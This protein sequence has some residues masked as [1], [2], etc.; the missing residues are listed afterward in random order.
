MKN[1]TK[2]LIPL[3][4]I[5]F[6]TPILSTKKSLTLQNTLKSSGGSGIKS[7]GF[8]LECGIPSGPYP[9]GSI[10]L[11]KTDKWE[12]HPD[13]PNKGCDC[14]EN[15]RC[16]NLEF[17]TIG[18]QNKKDFIK[19]IKDAGVLFSNFNIY[20]F[21]QSFVKDNDFRFKSE[22]NSSFVIERGS[23][24]E[25]SNG[26]FPRVLNSFITND[27]PHMTPDAN[28][29]YGCAPQVTV[30]LY[31]DKS[32]EF[33]L[34]TLKKTSHTHQDIF[35]KVLEGKLVVQSENKELDALVFVNNFIKNNKNTNIFENGE[36][37]AKSLSFLILFYFTALFK[38]E[39][40]GNDSL[41][42]KYSVGIM[43]RLTFSDM[44]DNLEEE[45][46]LRTCLFILNICSQH[47]EQQKQELLS[48]KNSCELLSFE[49]LRKCD[50]FKLKDYQNE[51][52][53][54]IHP[55]ESEERLTFTKWILSIVNPDYRLSLIKLREEDPSVFLP[56][57]D[58]LSPPE[59]LRVMG[60]NEK[61]ENN[62][63]RYGMGKYFLEDKNQV[64]VELRRFKK[65]E[66]MENYMNYRNGMNEL[67]KFMYG[68]DEPNIWREGSKDRG[69]D[70]VDVV[71][72]GDMI[73]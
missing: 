28:G 31:K 11:V 6:I 29:T 19:S 61:I 70:N 30:S 66:G 57:T 56:K 10:I 22:T 53:E 33:F 37:S 17:A 43:S 52:S 21:E 72:K 32:Y 42:L 41:E 73:I 7:S 45:I 15:I 18:G 62:E 36:E 39:N 51:E 26:N 44:Y 23:L 50:D 46:K 1:L 24:Y 67:L 49:N 60:K 58:L 48:T 69:Q 55:L 63:Y 8:E 3:V 2:I 13:T 4:I 65:I 27:T 25:H 40:F 54:F 9:E 20:G 47:T 64:L 59:G 12:I 16:V 38:T 14:T 5:T 34:K 35:L 68:D 71:S